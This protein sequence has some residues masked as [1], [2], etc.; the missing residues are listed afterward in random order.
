MM[1]IKLSIMVSQVSNWRRSKAAFLPNSGPKHLQGRIFIFVK[2]VDA[3]PCFRLFPHCQGIILGNYDDRKGT[4][5]CYNEG[6]QLLNMQ[7]RTN[8]VSC[9]CFRV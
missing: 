4:G 8:N 5:P 3:T 9:P 2:S 1:D 7:K 6:P